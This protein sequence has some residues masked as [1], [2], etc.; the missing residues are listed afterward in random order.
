MP[1]DPSWWTNSTGYGA[2]DHPLPRDHR[3]TSP[4]SSGATCSTLAA[5]ELTDR[6][7][8]GRRGALEVH[9][10]A[11][12][13]TSGVVRMSHAA[14]TMPRPRIE[15]AVATLARDCHTSG[16]ADTLCPTRNLL[17]FVVRP[18]DVR[19]VAGADLLAGRGDDTLITQ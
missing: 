17:R 18:S 13:S 4:R 7:N 3:L 9:R 10:G 1:V 5:A 2:S 11:H 8:V 6:A 19:T 16:E 12:C 15:T 14:G